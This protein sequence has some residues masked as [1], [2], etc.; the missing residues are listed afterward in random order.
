M[1]PDYLDF[2][3]R[4]FPFRGL[5]ERVLEGI[6][7]EIGV[8]IRTFSKEEIIFSDTVHQ[9]KI[10]F[11]I[12]GECLVEKHRAFDQSVTLNSISRYGSFGILAIIDPD[13]D[14]PTQIRAARSSTVL[15]IDGND[16]LEII[17]K[18]P[19][20]AMNVIKFLASRIAFLNQ[21][22][23]TF[24]GKS[25]RKKLASYL[26]MRYNDTGEIISV[27]RTMI[28]SEISVGRASLYRDLD[29]LEA[30]G[31][32]KNEQRKIIIIC[33]EGLERIKK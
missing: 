31:L 23:D 22:I 30:E 7:S 28:A 26:L 27:P 32:I 25:T 20:V 12:D 33:P 13:S 5:R 10:G 4:L 16:M 21:K 24:S 1:K 6:F 15:F 2:V 17:K 14:Y 9:N 18:Y 11:V 8:D 19:T 3:S 29:A